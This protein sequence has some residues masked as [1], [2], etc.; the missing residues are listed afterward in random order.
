MY[1]DGRTPLCQ[2]GRSTGYRESSHCNMLAHLI[3]GVPKRKRGNEAEGGMP[4]MDVSIL[5]RWI[6][7]F[8]V[9][10]VL[11]MFFVFNLFRQRSA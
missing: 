4:R 2:R 8:L 7:V 6:V 1:M 3:R 11:L 5:I 9:I 10:F